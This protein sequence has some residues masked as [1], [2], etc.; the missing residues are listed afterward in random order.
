MSDFEQGGIENAVPVGT[1]IN[2]DLN[3]VVDNEAVLD[4]T[5]VDDS[6]SQEEA[7]TAADGTSEQ[8]DG[9]PFTLNFRGKQIVPKSK[10][11]LINLAQQGHRFNQRMSAL[12]QQ[13]QQLKARAARYA[14]LEQLIQRIEAEP[15]FKKHIF[16]YKQQSGQ[17]QENTPISEDVIKKMIQPHLQE[18]TALKE[19][20]EERNAD[21][22][23]E[24]ETTALKTKYP[25]EDWDTEDE[26]GETF[27]HDVYR[28]ALEH[29]LPLETA[30]R[31]IKYDSIAV[32]SEAAALKRQRDQEITNRKKGIVSTGGSQVES[33][34]QKVNFR[35][36][37]Y[38]DLAKLAANDP[39]IKLSGA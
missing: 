28:H 33:V 14:Q 36:A 8:W 32:N 37:G 25:N 20:L 30:Y 1:D 6:V 23:L 4:D 26:N 13:E 16:N 35:K 22:E 11:E 10:E 38:N 9:T 19:Q 12:N 5:V 3:G 21:I 24:K 15:D 18:V 2:D 34:P 31:D 17:Q 29:N 7:S 39:D 27:L